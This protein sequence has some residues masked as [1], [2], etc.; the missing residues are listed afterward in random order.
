MGRS[1]KRIRPGFIY[2]VNV[3][4]LTNFKKGCRKG[5][6][7]TTTSNRRT[8]A[9]GASK[10]AGR[11]ATA[12]Q[13]PTGGRPPEGH[14]LGTQEVLETANLVVLEKSNHTYILFSRF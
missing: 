5:G 1:S 11:V 7:G 3:E 2:L 6:D 12:L 4:A 14:L 13:P 8:T 10:D 9:G